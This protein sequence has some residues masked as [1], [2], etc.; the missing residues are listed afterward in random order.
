ML[1][2]T[3]FDIATEESASMLEKSNHKGAFEYLPEAKEKSYVSLLN[4][5]QG[6]SFTIQ[7]VPSEK[8][9]AT[10]NSLIAGGNHLHLLSAA[11]R[12]FLQEEKCKLLSLS[13]NSQITE[14]KEKKAL[15]VHAILEGS[16]AELPEGLLDR[17]IRF[18]CMTLSIEQP[19]TE[20]S[21]EEQ[22]SLDVL[23]DTEKRDAENEQ[24]ASN[25]QKTESKIE[26]NSDIKDQAKN[27]MIKEDPREIKMANKRKE[28]ISSD[29]SSKI[30]DMEEDACENTSVHADENLDSNIDVRF[31]MPQKKTRTLTMENI[32]DIFGI[33][34][35]L[36][37]DIATEFD[38]KEEMSEGINENEKNEEMENIISEETE[39]ESNGIANAN[40]NVASNTESP[41][42]DVAELAEIPDDNLN[43]NDDYLEK[44]END[45]D[46]TK[47][48]SGKT[49]ELSQAELH[50]NSSKAA[51]FL[52]LIDEYIPESNLENI[53]LFREYKDVDADI[54]TTASKT[55]MDTLFAQ[56]LNYCYKNKNSELNHAQMGDTNPENFLKTIS[57]YVD[58]S[59]DL[60]V[61]D[62]KM[63]MDKIKR[64]LF[65]YYVLIPLIDDPKVSDIKILA[66]DKIN[67]KI[68]GIHYSVK[69]LQ[70][71]D[72]V[73]YILFVAGLMRRNHAVQA[74]GIALFTDVMFCKD[75][76]LRFNITLPQLNVSQYPIVHIR[77]T[78]KEKMMVEDLINAGMMDEK[79]SA[80]IQDKIRTSRG[81][82]FAGP[83][84]SGK[85][86][87]LNAFVE[88]IPFVDSGLVIQESDEV[89]SK[90][91]PNLMCQHIWKHKD[92]TVVTGMDRLGENG[93][94][95]D[96]KYFIIGEIKG[97]EARDFLRACNTGHICLCT[98][99]T[100]SAEETIPRFAD[101]V[102]RG[103]D[104][105][106]EEAER[107]LKDLEVIVYINKF[108]V[109][110]IT[111]VLGYDDEKHKLIYRTVYLRDYK[112]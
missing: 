3:T 47:S 31:N 76:I 108:K 57:V 13:H 81:V 18:I 20:Q 82:V 68:D 29:K 98:V 93:L 101:Y 39:L 62:K 105:T 65:S 104:Y 64:A 44:K 74:G 66:P 16:I 41:F 35:Q 67:V 58:K 30:A 1:Q 77:K 70:F 79:I 90:N 56:A 72:D 9:G 23:K 69:G 19:N 7:L 2:I 102:K 112:A 71:I 89:F 40:S 25:E 63:F 14:N 43:E 53:E 54:K 10:E 22:E 60:P 78:E 110:E 85:S 59:L 38:D 5:K 28:N 94:V 86:K 48:D 49:K 34:E 21:S 6:V 51:P 91:H 33:N 36:A 111:E 103:A 73:D 96:V 27:E 42:G 11:R 61:E 55:K 26:I 15:I 8:E 80:Y 32:D 37:T 99:H 92:G 97:A 100:P 106:M 84:A 17:V 52:N 45:S 88:T 4:G 95:C 83:S 107:L 46:N 24:S 109:Q 50:A 75:Y 87:A 12:A